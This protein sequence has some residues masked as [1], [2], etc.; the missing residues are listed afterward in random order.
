M[1]AHQ[2]VRELPDW[3]PPLS[4]AVL[5]VVLARLVEGLDLPTV[6]RPPTGPEGVR[7]ARL[8]ENQLAEAEPA[9]LWRDTPPMQRPTWRT[10]LPAAA[11][12]RLERNLA[13]LERE[14]L[15]FLCRYGT[16]FSGAPD[17]RD[18]LDLLALT[19][20]PP[21]AA[22]GQRRPHRWRAANLPHRRL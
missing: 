16:P 3:H 15:R 6:Y 22:P 9:K 11:L 12:T 19:N 1:A 7:F 10:L 5:G 13:A 4:D 18:L 14:E 2:L 20:L 8:L 21:T 17:P